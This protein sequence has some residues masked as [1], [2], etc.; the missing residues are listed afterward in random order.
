MGKTN[1]QNVTFIFIMNESFN[2]IQGESLSAWDLSHHQNSFPLYSLLSI[3]GLLSLE[4]NL[5][6]FAKHIECTETNTLQIPRGKWSN[7]RWGHLSWYN[8]D[9][10]TLRE[11]IIG[12]ISDVPSMPNMS[13][14]SSDVLTSFKGKMSE[15]TTELGFLICSW[16]CHLKRYT[17]MYSYSSF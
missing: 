15:S 12:E 9:N 13:L 7:F 17:S 10:L 6:V 16:Q 11:S 4:A 5:T 1:L 8:S 3:Q 2:T 14:G